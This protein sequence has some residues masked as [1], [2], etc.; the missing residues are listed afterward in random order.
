MDTNVIIMNTVTNEWF[1]TT[2]MN[3]AMAILKDFLKPLAR[4]SSKIALIKEDVGESRWKRTDKIIVVPPHLKAFV[5]SNTKY[6]SIYL[7]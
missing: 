6:T 2:D 1:E 7:E 3:I 5:R 4:L